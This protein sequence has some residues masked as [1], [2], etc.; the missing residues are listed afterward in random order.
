M[1]AVSLYALNEYVRRV[2]Q[3]NFSEPVWI[4]AELA[5]VNQSKGHWY[6]ELVEKDPAIDQVIARAQ[7]TI[8][9]RRFAKLQRQYRK[10]MDLEQILVAGATCRLLVEIRFSERFGYSLNIQDLDPDFSLGQLAQQRE[11]ALRALQE[12]G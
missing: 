11:R 3:L 6:I 12:G 9:S 7:G 1:S 4:D 2:I 5:Q 10:Q 8:W